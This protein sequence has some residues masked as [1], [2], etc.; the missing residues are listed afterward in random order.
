[1]PCCAI[2][3]GNDNRESGFADTTQVSNMH[4]HLIVSEFDRDV[5]GSLNTA[6]ANLQK[7]TS[8]PAPILEPMHELLVS[9]VPKPLV[10]AFEDV[11]EAAVKVEPVQDVVGRPYRGTRATPRAAKV[12]RDV[13]VVDHWPG[14]RARPTASQR[15]AVRGSGIAYADE[16]RKPNS[17]SKPPA[18]ADPEVISPSSGTL[19]PVQESGFSAESCE[20]PF[21]ASVFG[22]DFATGSVLRFLRSGYAR[23]QKPEASDVK[24]ESY[25]RVW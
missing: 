7:T 20:P 5:P 6:R 16:A 10:G 17:P 2:R 15:Q 4:K 23:P 11:S 19:E 24:P 22:A 12:P 25:F 21:M 8:R 14:H 18:G 13:K 1:M 3:P 9:L